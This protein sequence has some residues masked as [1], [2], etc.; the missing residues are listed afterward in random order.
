MIGAYIL[1]TLG[2]AVWALIVPL[3]KHFSG[4]VMRSV[5]VFGGAFLLAVCIL[6]LLPQVAGM[7]LCLESAGNHSLAMLPYFAIL[8]GFLVQQVLERL[9][10]HAEHG[11][12]ETENHHHETD[13]S[14]LAGLMIGLSLHALLEGMP[15]VS[16]SLSVDHGL[17]WGIFIH[18]IPVALILISL[19]VDRGIGFWRILVLLLLFGIM[20]P[21]G[22][23]LNI[24]LVQ[25][26]RLL[27]HII[28][29]LVVGVLL[30][31][32]SSIL[33]DHKQ[34][35]ASWLNIAL[36]VLAFTLAFFTIH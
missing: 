35:H 29:G 10:A 12:I 20:S 25:P 32:S 18:N 8:A 13:R 14:P 15:L 31:V 19:M 34:H 9:S 23:M 6:D 16:Q 24:Y 21:L 17:M 33:F 4:L 7:H 27:Q 1:I 26:G 11:H 36:C 22:S 5:T 2:V 28:L 30:H 3:G